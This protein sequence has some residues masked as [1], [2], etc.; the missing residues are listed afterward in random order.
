MSKQIVLTWRTSDSYWLP[1]KTPSRHLSLRLSSVSRNIHTHYYKITQAVRKILHRNLNHSETYRWNVI[2]S[3]D[4]RSAGSPSTHDK[5]ASGTPYL[6]KGVDNKSSGDCSRPEDIDRQVSG[7][8]TV[9]R[10]HL[11]GKVL[12]A[13][14]RHGLQAAGADEVTA[15]RRTSEFLRSCSRNTADLSICRIA[16]KCLLVCVRASFRLKCEH[17]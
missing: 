5:K 2:S 6:F 13:S 10:G 11:R 1:L 3:R 14:I 12:E 17:E 7:S 15:L 16:W 4:N 9:L 8:L